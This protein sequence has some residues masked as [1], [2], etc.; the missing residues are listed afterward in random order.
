MI[1]VQQKRGQTRGLRGNKRFK[2]EKTPK[3]KLKRMSFSSD[4]LVGIG[5][6]IGVLFI[7]FGGLI[8]ISVLM[9]PITIIPNIVVIGI[10]SVLV[11][12]GV[13]LL[14]IASRKL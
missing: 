7:L 12:V 13:S 11:G 8:L 1:R 2:T 5:I 9:P 6:A 4:F 3:N 14:I 10:G